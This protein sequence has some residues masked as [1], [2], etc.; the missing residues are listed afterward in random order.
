MKVIFL[1]LLLL[2]G[3]A[4]FTQE[5]NVKAPPLSSIYLDN[6]IF[7]LKWDQARSKNLLSISGNGGYASNAI[8]AEFFNA[9][10][11]KYFIDEELK[12]KASKRLSP[13]NVF[14]L[15]NSLG[16]DV[17]LG[18]TF[19]RF[20]DSLV[21]VGKAT[22]FISLRHRVLSDFQYTSD[23][24]DILFYGNR[25]FA[26]ETAH[27]AESYLNN[28]RFNQLQIGLKK[29][30][31]CNNNAFDV[32]V[33]LSFLQGIENA[34]VT[35][36]R[37]SIYTQEDGE[38]LD[39]DIDFQV[40]MSDTAESDIFSFNG[41]GASTDLFLSFTSKNGNQWRFALSDIGF[42]SWSDRSLEYKNDTSFRFIGFEIPS[43]I[44]LYGNF[45]RKFEEDTLMRLYGLQGVKKKY[46]TI[47]P[48]KLDVN[49]T[50]QVVPNKLWMTTGLQKR[51][52]TNSI[53]L[54]WLKP[55]Y[56]FTNELMVSFYSGYGG[57]AGHGF[58]L[59]LTGLTYGLEV[60]KHFGKFH[61]VIGSRAIQGYFFPGRQPGISGY[62][63]IIRTF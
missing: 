12:D 18:I 1:L 6:H 21:K 43:I 47:L 25:K 36:N 2:S 39:V 13:T 42:I 44:E 53:P 16:M 30:L 48:V 15:N 55:S 8:N 14:G 17:D 38:Y 49:Y 23:L 33:A 50:F 61:V 46:T 20:S 35:I 7:N 32:G 29:T 4:G 34:R 26:G 37:G 22:Y 9:F 11:L 54:F 52:F 56:L 3:L 31:H 41:I 5:N 51:F 63:R 45:F 62:S 58:G 28:Y 24:F 27:F 40:N 59:D 10:L 57:F 60:N 19:A